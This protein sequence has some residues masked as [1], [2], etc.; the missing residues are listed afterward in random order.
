[1]CYCKDHIWKYGAHM[2]CTIVQGVFEDIR[3]NFDNEFHNFYSK[4]NS[5]GKRVRKDPLTKRRTVGRQNLRNNDVSD[6]P[7]DY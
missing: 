6:I 2:K 4:A 7:E 5:V 1:M 3:N